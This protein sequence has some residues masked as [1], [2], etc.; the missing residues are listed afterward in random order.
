MRAESSQSDDFLKP[1][2][3]PESSRSAFFVECHRE[4][5]PLYQ[6]RCRATWRME[7]LRILNANRDFYRIVFNTH[8]YYKCS[9]DV[10]MFPV[11]GHD[12]PNKYFTMRDNYIII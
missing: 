3:R 10:N 1:P 12:I 6:Y 5:M 7:I 2:I 4:I 9:M 8:S 11:Y